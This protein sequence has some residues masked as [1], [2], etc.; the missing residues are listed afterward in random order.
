MMKKFLAI[1]LTL[2]KVSL[3]GLLFS[4]NM[5]GN[6][7]MAMEMPCSKMMPS[8]AQCEI[9]T[10]AVK[11]LSDPFVQ[12][13]QKKLEVKKFA[14]ILQIPLAPFIKGE[15][16]LCLESEGCIFPP[17]KLLSRNSYL[18]AKNKIVLVI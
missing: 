11:N 16:I 10:L 2:S 12:V 8:Q 13:E 7:A 14:K 1:S 4:M 9:C 15:S 6:S 17:P 3:L 18:F 5:W